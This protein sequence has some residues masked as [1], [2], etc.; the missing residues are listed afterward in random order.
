MRNNYTKYKEEEFKKEELLAIAAANLEL[1]DTRKEQMIS[2]YEAVNDVFLEFK[3]AFIRSV[4]AFF[5][6]FS[7][8]RANFFDSNSST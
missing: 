2:A 7:L 1:D 8:I 6:F 3:S 4:V 5:K